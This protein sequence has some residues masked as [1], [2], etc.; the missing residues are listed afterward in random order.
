MFALYPTC[1]YTLPTRGCNPKFVSL[2]DE[3][4]HDFPVQY[5]QITYLHS[6]INHL[7]K[8][9]PQ[10]FDFRFDFCKVVSAIGHARNLL[11]RLNYVVIKDFNDDLAIASHVADR[12]RHLKN[13]ITVRISRMNETIPSRIYGLEPPSMESLTAIR[14]IF[15][16][17]EITAYV[18]AAHHDDNLNCGQLAGKYQ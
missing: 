3:L 10:A 5:L 15:D 13:K 17:E 6:D 4:A 9:I 2:V 8:I 12:I 14:E 16:S 18:F 7:S 11:I 1:F